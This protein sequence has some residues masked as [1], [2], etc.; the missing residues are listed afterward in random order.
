MQRREPHIIHF[1]EFENVKRD[2]HRR[3][4]LGDDGYN[5]CFERLDDYLKLHGTETSKKDLVMF[6]SEFFEIQNQIRRD[7]ESAEELNKRRRKLKY[8]L[9]D[10]ISSLKPTGYLNYEEGSLR[11]NSK[12]DERE[13]LTVCLQFDRDFPYLDKLFSLFELAWTS[14]TTTKQYFIDAEN[15][16]I[17]IEIEFEKE[18]Y[19]IGTESGETVK[20]PEDFESVNFDKESHYIG[21]G[22]GE[23]VKL[24]EDFESGNFEKDNNAQVEN[25]S[26]EIKI[27][28]WKDE[29]VAMRIRKNYLKTVPVVN[30]SG[31][32]EVGMVEEQAE[33]VVEKMDRRFQIGISAVGAS[34]AKC[35]LVNELLEWF[36]KHELFVN[37]G[38]ERF[39]ICIPQAVG[40]RASEVSPTE[41][42]IFMKQPV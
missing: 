2:C 29:S 37:G 32:A 26:P 42:S 23:T 38:F 18:S 22:S 13:N 24:L 9:L 1:Q 33:A 25:K 31:E 35:A 27:G 6:R 41:L 4:S 39:A 12:W 20:L 17:V 19:Y 21:T 30:E 16:E 3:L 36:E 40:F 8:A 28:H 10:F 11:R 5:I 15:N 7:T 14:F 34:E